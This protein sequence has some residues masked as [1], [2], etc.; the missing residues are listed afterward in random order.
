MQRNQLQPDILKWFYSQ[1]NDNPGHN[2]GF[3]GKTDLIQT[4]NKWQRKRVRLGAE[5]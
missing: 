2:H 3:H 4:I 1:W 5:K